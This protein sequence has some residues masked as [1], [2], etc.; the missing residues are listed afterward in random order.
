VNV[1]ETVRN[2]RGLRAGRLVAV[3]AVLLGI[4]VMHGLASSH[5]A[6]AAAAAHPAVAAMLH[7]A[8]AAD[9]HQS[10]L[11]AASAQQPAGQRSVPDSCD[12]DCGPVVLLCL[13]VL[14]VTVGV[15]VALVVVRRRRRATGAYERGTV[16]TPAG[17]RSA[18]PP[19]D[20]VREL[21]VNRT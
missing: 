8:A 19:P 10:A 20:P 14:V 5:H 2:G 18:L 16:P 12:G 13:A 4:L 9:P 17:T 15:A 6:P 1:N 11:D 7:H 21:C 3:L